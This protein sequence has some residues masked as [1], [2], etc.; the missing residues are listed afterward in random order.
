[1]NRIVFAA[2]VAA[3]SSFACGTGADDD[4]TET[5]AAPVEI[6]LDNDTGRDFSEV[7]V[8]HGTGSSFGYG[9]L[10]ASETS[11]Y[12]TAE[13]GAFRYAYVNAATDIGRYVVQ[14]I[15]YVGEATLTAGRY[16]YRLYRTN[17]STTPDSVVDGDAFFY[18][19][20]ELRED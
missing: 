18:L 13:R 7:T 19:A 17:T 1:M 2:A 5:A 10:G 9:A 20:L 3:L 12:A 11:D 16:T 14:P 15:D 4:G 8:V 6:R